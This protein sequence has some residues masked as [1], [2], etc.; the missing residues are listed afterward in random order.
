AKR[1]AAMAADNFALAREMAFWKRRV[2]REWDSIEVL[3]YDHPNDSRDVLTLGSES[4]SRIKLY[5]GT[6]SVED[7]GV[8]MVITRFTKDG[9]TVIDEIIPYVP[10]QISNGEVTYVGRLTP[11]TAGSYYVAS[12]IYA[13]N[14]NMPHRQD[15]ALVKWL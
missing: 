12:R 4:V 11:Q 3:E 5:L 8:E 2:E 15:F 13:Y 7:I 14:S 10:E 1:H 6:L 9:E